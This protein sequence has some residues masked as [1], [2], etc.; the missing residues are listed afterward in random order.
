MVMQARQAA[1]AYAHVGLQT[2]AM[3]ANPHQLI[4]MLFDGAHAALKKGQWAIAQN[5]LAAKGIALTKAIDIIERGL[6][7]ALDFDQGK[8]IAE[9]LDSLYDYMIRSLM[10]AN[11]RND[12]QLIADV[13]TLLGNISSAW[14]QIGAPRAAPV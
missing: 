11:L 9:Q 2:G 6:R 10:R 14:K 1:S 8:E 12:A 4:T 7:G 13:D 3:S 5:D